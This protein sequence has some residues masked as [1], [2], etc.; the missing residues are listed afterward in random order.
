MGMERG[1][2]CPPGPSSLAL[3]TII[4]SLTTYWMWEGELGRLSY[5][6]RSGDIITRVT[7]VQ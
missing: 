1:E 6:Q 3:G 7:V 2:A 5:S 4:P